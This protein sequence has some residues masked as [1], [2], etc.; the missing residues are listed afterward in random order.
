MNDLR[1]FLVSIGWAVDEAGEKKWLQAIQGIDK[2]AKG[3]A[4]ALAG[5]AA[6]VTAIVV[7][8]ADAY[9]VLAFSAER[10]LSA[11]SNLQALT[12]AL[13]QLGMGSGAAGRVMDGFAK[14]LRT[15]PST[16]GVLRAIGVQTRANGVLR[17]TTD[18]LLDAVVA[19]D[20][21]DY[22]QA[23]N[24]AAQLGISESDYSQLRGKASEIRRL[25]AEALDMSQGIN[26]QGAVAFMASYRL[27][28]AQFELTVDA[29][30][31]SVAPAVAPII[32]DLD[33]WIK[34][35]AEQ[36]VAFSRWLVEAAVALARELANVIAKLAEVWGAARDMIRS[37]TG[38]DGLVSAMEAVGGAYLAAVALRMGGPVGMLAA[39][40]LALAGMILATTSADAQTAAPA[41]PPPT[42]RG[43][44]RRMR[45]KASGWLGG[46]SGGN[47]GHGG[48][49]GGNSSGGGASSGGGGNSN[50]WG[51]GAPGDFAP[52]SDAES[53]GVLAADRQKFADELKDPE[54]AARL[55]AYVEAEVGGQGEKAQRAFIESIM[56][57]ADARGQ[58]LR[59]TLDGSYFPRET[60][61][62]ARRYSRDPR[63]QEKHKKAIE[64]VLGGSNSSGYATGNASGS[65]G[66]AGG[67]RTSSYGGENFGIEGPDLKWARRKRE[68]VEGGKA[69]NK[70]GHQQDQGGRDEPRDDLPKPRDDRRSA[71]GADSRTDNVNGTPF[72]LQDRFAAA[73]LTA[74]PEEAFDGRIKQV[75][76]INV[77][78]DADPNETASSVER[79]QRRTNDTMIDAAGKQLV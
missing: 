59:K 24:I 31:T 67:P 28:V 10:T 29:L 52:S 37:A 40:I 64:A 74:S 3:I 14:R 58:T 62:R 70:D 51:A 60:H 63:I 72:S 7:R 36:I 44:W 35:H 79:A 71:L 73:P 27:L 32:D 65:V 39:A 15:L 47:G 13:R 9:S 2:L 18:L 19:L 8:T 46:S 53:S 33:V 4:A 38:R 68:Q 69:R 23:A 77:D 34:R 61:E 41:K 30:V 11:A 17:D 22:V 49:G 21:R 42:P 75:T 55:A 16:E 54:V 76:E 5:A 25:K 78:G 66:F 26:G 1:E 48:A 56:N 6:A 45:D 57:R 12:Y 20:G 43:F 50:G